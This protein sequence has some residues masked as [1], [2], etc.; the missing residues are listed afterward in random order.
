MPRRDEV[1]T[2]RA[3][4]FEKQSE[5]DFPVAHHVGIRGDAGRIGADQVVDDMLLIRFFQVEDVEGDAELF[6]DEAGVLRVLYGAAVDVKTLHVHASDVVS[7]LFED[8]GC[9]GRVHAARQSHKHLCMISVYNIP[10]H[11]FYTVKWC[12]SKV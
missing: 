4:L 8:E 9:D 1:G 2:E 12:I 6:C 11:F 5:L 7:A 3:G 10:H